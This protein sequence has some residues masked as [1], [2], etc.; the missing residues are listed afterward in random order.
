M[1]ILTTNYRKFTMNKTNQN[2]GSNNSYGGNNN[3]NVNNA[4]NSN[5][6]TKL[7]ITTGKENSTNISLVLLVVIVL[8]AI[9]T[10]SFKSLLATAISFISNTNTSTPETYCNF[11]N[12]S[13]TDLI[14]RHKNFPFSSCKNTTDICDAFQK[15]AGGITSIGNLCGDEKNPYFDRNGITYNTINEKTW[16]GIPLNSYENATIKILQNAPSNI[17][18]LIQDTTWL[19]SQPYLRTIHQNETS[20]TVFLPGISCLSQ[21]SVEKVFVDPNKFNLEIYTLPNDFSGIPVIP[22]A[23]LRL[24]GMPYVFEGITVPSKWSIEKRITKP[25]SVSCKHNELDFVYVA[26]NFKAG[27]P[28]F[29][30]TEPTQPDEFQKIPLYHCTDKQGRNV[31]TIS[32]FGNESVSRSLT[33]KSVTH[34]KGI[35]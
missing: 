17:K 30:Y 12:L 1:K 31:V 18:P 8:T 29:S 25:F 5:I 21:N 14:A 4:N 23:Q 19:R 32:D 3:E 34:F 2:K 10:D 24:G 13:K 9:C 20:N 11:E 28:Y 7:P 15:A 6:K 33:I 26:N 27:D 35:S 16:K 22:V